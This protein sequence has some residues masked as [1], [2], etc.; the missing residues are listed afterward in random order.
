MGMGSSGAAW[1][2]SSGGALPP[3]LKISSSVNAR[4]APPSPCTGHVRMLELRTYSWEA[5]TMR[6]SKGRPVRVSQNGNSRT[7]SIPATIV[8]DEK[9]EAGEVFVVEAQPGGLFYRRASAQ[10]D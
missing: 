7:L 5:A 8:D 4:L 1:G 3:S 9:I 6:T 2:K 10:P